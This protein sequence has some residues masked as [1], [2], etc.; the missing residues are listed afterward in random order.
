M[1][2]LFEYIFDGSTIWLM[3]LIPLYVLSTIAVLL[4]FCIIEPL[5]R[6]L[7]KNHLDIPFVFITA[8][9]ITAWQKW[10]DI[11]SAPVTFL[12]FAGALLLCTFITWF[13]FDVLIG[14]PATSGKHE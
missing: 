8:I 1:H 10:D 14:K 2:D 3:I 13:V 11:T 12:L 5:F 6:F 9:S 7:R 4:W